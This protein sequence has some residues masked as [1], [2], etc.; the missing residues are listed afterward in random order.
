[1]EHINLQRMSSAEGEKS[2]LSAPIRQ[3]TL[4]FTVST[5]AD[6]G[7]HEE[8]AQTGEEREEVTACKDS[9][10]AQTD[11]E[12]E[13]HTYSDFPHPKAER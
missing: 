6:S 5:L 3:K 4:L 13:I 7:T 11:G 10:R 8:P 2:E 1:M 12:E 9:S